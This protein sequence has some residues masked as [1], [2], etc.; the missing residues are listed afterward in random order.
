MKRKVKANFCIRETQSYL[1]DVLLYLHQ[2]HS[3]P[4]GVEVHPAHEHTTG[5]M[6]ILR[7]CHSNVA[8]MS[9]R[10]QRD[11]KKGGDLGVMLEGY[12]RDV[13][14]T[15]RSQHIPYPVPS[16]DNGHTS[17]GWKNTTL[18]TDMAQVGVTHNKQWRWGKQ[19]KS[20]LAA[21]FP[22]LIAHRLIQQPVTAHQPQYYSPCHWTSWRLFC[23][24]GGI[25]H[26]TVDISICLPCEGK[27]I[28]ISFFWRKT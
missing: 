21:H 10:C 20:A 5:A 7:K 1:W 3:N 8:W 24:Q 15:R 18:M 13:E 25:R 11:Q 26:N 27:A 14:G 19:Q 22:M 16:S 6:A 12:K 23:L 2:S 9:I 4:A 28:T 17:S